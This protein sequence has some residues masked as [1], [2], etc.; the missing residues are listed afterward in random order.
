MKKMK[1]N[2]LRSELT[3]RGL[4]TK[5]LKQVLVDRLLAAL[6]DD[7]PVEMATEVKKEPEPAAEESAAANENGTE[8]KTEPKEAIEEVDE[9]PPNE[10]MAEDAA[11]A[12]EVSEEQN[13]E[14]VVKEEP[15]DSTE[16]ID[17]QEAK[18]EE[19]E[20][21]ESEV[22]VEETPETENEQIQDNKQDSIMQEVEP[23][24]GG[25]G[26]YYLKHFGHC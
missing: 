3:K 20:K 19:E 12:E 21:M 6:E 8:V 13:E 25:K 17:E 23:Q 24:D 14:P 18:V 15:Q 4:D 9:Q 26:P 5:G 7:Q 2:D 11:V 10:L 16:P 22:K 1:V